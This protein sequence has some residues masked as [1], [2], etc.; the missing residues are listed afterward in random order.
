MFTTIPRS[1]V[2]DK[3]YVTT[4]AMSGAPGSLKGMRIGIIRES[5]LIYPNEKADEPIVTAAV[6]EIY[7]ACGQ[8]ATHEAP[9][10]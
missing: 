1:V 3:P 4:A 9:A 6:N 10:A 8:R 7:E 2:L 5:M